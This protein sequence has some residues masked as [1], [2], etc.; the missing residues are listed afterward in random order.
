MCSECAAMGRGTTGRDTHAIP[1][2]SSGKETQRHGQVIYSFIHA[3]VHPFI[4]SL[5]ISFAHLFINSVALSFIHHVFV[6]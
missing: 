4:I 1:F 6:H 3:F 5:Y 2:V